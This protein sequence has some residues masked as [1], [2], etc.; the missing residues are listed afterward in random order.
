[1]VFYLSPLSSR[2]G[3]LVSLKERDISPD[4]AR[5]IDAAEALLLKTKKHD[6]TE[7]DFKKLAYLSV[8]DGSNPETFCLV[9][10]LA[11]QNVEQEDSYFITNPWEDVTLFRKKLAEL[12]HCAREV[13]SYRHYFSYARI[14][15]QMG[16]MKRSTWQTDNFD[17]TTKSG[18]VFNPISFINQRYHDARLKYLDQLLQHLDLK[19][20]RFFYTLVLPEHLEIKVKFDRPQRINRIQAN[21]KQRKLDSGRK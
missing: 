10:M 9:G 3:T 11:L 2:R 13:F 6:S 12:V 7:T 1:M 20:T 14:K 16:P 21:L 17:V 5:I 19:A 8:L 18:F 4:D 15:G